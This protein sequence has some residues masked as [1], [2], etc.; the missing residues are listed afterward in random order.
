MQRALSFIIPLFLTLGVSAQVPCNRLPD[1]SKLMKDLA[2]RPVHGISPTLFRIGC[3]TNS[4]M[5]RRILEVLNWRWSRVELDAYLL[6]KID[7]VAIHKVSKEN[8]RLYDSLLEKNR[9]DLIDEM[10]KKNEFRVETGIVLLPARLY[11]REAIPVLEKALLDS[12]HYS[13]NAV[14]L[15]LARLGN[16]K[17]QNEILA[18]C[19]NSRG[20]NDWDWKTDAENK[21]RKLMFICSQESIYQLASFM[22]TS[23]TY[24]PSPGHGFRQLKSTSEIIWSLSKML[25]N[26][27]FSSRYDWKKLYN[28]E[29]IDSDVI[30]YCKKWL[31]SN[32]GKYQLNKDYIV[33]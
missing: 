26:K 24:N 22:D 33:Y 25:L 28:L 14:Q 15:S 31:L 11:M 10:T 8:V 19:S 17:A 21:S 20:L 29:Q 23:Q 12:L 3:N 4:A 30:M 7:T 27:D 1:S 2:E 32:K 6:K 18:Q 13:R 9:K 16:R 5:K